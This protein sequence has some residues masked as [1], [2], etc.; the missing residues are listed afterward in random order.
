MNFLDLNWDVHHLIAK[1][2]TT[3]E[4]LSLS[5][6]DQTLQFVIGDVLRRKFAINE[7]ILDC[8]F[9]LREP[10]EWEFY[11]NEHRHAITFSHLPMI[12]RV[13]KHFDHL[14]ARLN[15]FHNKCE[16][17]TTKEMYQLIYSQCADNL[18][19]FASTSNFNEHFDEFK[20]P[21]KNVRQVSFEGN[22]RHLNTWKFTF[23]EL[24]PSLTR[25]IL[26]PY[27]SCNIH[28]IG[29][30]NEI[31]PNLRHLS[32]D[33]SIDQ[34]LPSIKTILSKHLQLESL[35]LKYAD[36]NL[37]QY[38]DE[39]LPHLEDVELKLYN[40]VNDDHFQFNFERLKRFILNGFMRNLPTNI[41]FRNLE[42]F[43]MNAMA[44]NSAKLVELALQSKTSLKKLRLN[45]ELNSLNVCELINGNLDLVE[46]KF[47]CGKEL[48]FNYVIELI[49]SNNNLQSVEIL[50]DGNKQANKNAAFNLF[51]KHFANE[52]AISKIDYFIN[53]KRKS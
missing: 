32:A 17:N 1:D 51:Q 42:E 7:I 31:M 53:L 10:R 45:V 52:W 20:T 36:A 27:S 23:S 3:Y 48:N 40:Q 49:E 6:V 41:I 24:F 12:H 21:L 4:L 2:L 34:A 47:S 33:C 16:A 9:Y 13:L 29:I 18:T 14:I 28:S 5:E 22:Y 39:H 15:F 37:L 35:F 19:E 25:L 38:V 46:L 30:S 43:Q 44:P 50:F 26:N 11:Q 8:P